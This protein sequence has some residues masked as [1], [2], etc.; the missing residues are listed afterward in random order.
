M[1]M[2]Q[3]LMFISSLLL[4]IIILMESHDFELM[5]IAYGLEITEFYEQIW[6]ET[7]LF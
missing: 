7:N 6:T 3:I 5:N 4:R 1:I 2:K